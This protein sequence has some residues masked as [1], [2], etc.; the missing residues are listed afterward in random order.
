MDIGGIDQKIASENTRTA[1]APRSARLINPLI[2]GLLRLGIPVPPTILLT[3]RGR[4]SGKSRT[5]PVGLFELNNHRYLFSTFGET[6]WVHNLRKSGQATLR[7]GRRRETVLALELPLEEAASILKGA[8]TPYFRKRLMRSQL[9]SN[10]HV[11]PD[12]SAEDWN[13]AAMYHPAFEVHESP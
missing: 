12:S 8:L 7:R 3:V 1:H 11:S 4:K 6:N 13:N 10:Y 9:R 2:K 5:T